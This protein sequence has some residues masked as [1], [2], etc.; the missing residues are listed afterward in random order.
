MN[1]CVGHDVAAVSAHVAAQCKG[2]RVLAAMRA[3]R[4]GQHPVAEGIESEDVWSRL[5]ADGC[6]HLQRYLL[7]RPAAHP[8][9][10]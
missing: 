3:D 1:A 7:G 6:R 2:A 8:R 10:R 4:R 5:A 9:T